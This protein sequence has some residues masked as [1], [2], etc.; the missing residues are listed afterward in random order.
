[1]PIRAIRASTTN[2][3]TIFQSSLD[4]R[5]ESSTMENRASGAGWISLKAGSSEAVAFSGG[6]E[7]VSAGTAAPAANRLTMS[8]ADKTLAQTPERQKRPG[9]AGGLGQTV[10]LALDAPG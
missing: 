5:V 6:G 10:H 2:G 7:S 9:G 8:S 4:R 3:N 1:M